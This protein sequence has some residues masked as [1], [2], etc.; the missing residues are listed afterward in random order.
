MKKIFTVLFLA[1]FLLTISPFSELKTVQGES[2]GRIIL[3]NSQLLRCNS[4]DCFQLWS[5]DMKP[6]A[7][8]PN[9]ILI[10]MNQGC[11]YG[12]T[13]MYDK[14]VPLDRIKSGIDDLYKQ[15]SVSNSSDSNFYLWRVET[16]KFA[17]QLTVAGKAHEKRNVA[18]L[19][20]RQV[21]YIAFGGKSACD[22]S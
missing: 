2:L 22:N 7:L 18:E 5:G 12:I 1:M 21:I 17:I 4:S 15:W 11:I 6:D 10:D 14:S 16:E 13:A 3:P 20:A 19:G 8:R 9:Q